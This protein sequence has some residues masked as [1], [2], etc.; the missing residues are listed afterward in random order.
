MNPPNHLPGAGN[1][2]SGEGLGAPSALNKN[3]V[4]QHPGLSPLSPSLSCPWDAWTEVED[5]A[6]A[7]VMGVV[8][9]GF[10][11]EYSSLEKGAPGASLRQ[12]SPA[13]CQ[14]LSHVITYIPSRYF[15][16]SLQEV[17]SMPQSRAFGKE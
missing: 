13:W 9:G 12:L 2:W 8:G 17:S 4:V 14:S 7:E 15:M 6:M 5:W 10:I 16:K 3:S 1:G 11:P